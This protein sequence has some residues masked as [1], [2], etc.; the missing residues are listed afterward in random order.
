MTT[1]NFASIDFDL[2]LPA[3]LIVIDLQPCSVDPDFGL[4]KALEQARPAYALPG[5]QDASTVTQAVNAL[6][7]PSSRRPAGVLHRFRKRRRRRQRRD[8]RVDP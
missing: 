6:S 3:A 8:H 1:P 2:E 4:A 7:R 5:G